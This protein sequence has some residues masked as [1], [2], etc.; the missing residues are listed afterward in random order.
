MGPQSLN[1]FELVQELR[2][3]PVCH[4]L[5]FVHSN[6]IVTDDHRRA[7]QLGADGFL[8]KPMSKGQ[9]LKLLLQTVHHREQLSRVSVVSPGGRQDSLSMTRPHPALT[10][11]P[12]VKIIAVID[13][14]K[15]FR[16]QWPPFLKGFKTQLYSCAEDFL[17][18]WEH[19]KEYLHAVITDKFLGS[20][21]DGITFGNILR[22]QSANIPIILS[23]NELGAHGE[24]EIFDLVVDKDAAIEAPKITQHILAKN[25]R[26]TARYS[27]T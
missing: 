19:L 25:S 12:A 27:M 14:E 2:K 24:G 16:D 11:S 15:L 10:L 5:I 9:L 26:S 22:A 3:N 8:P 1:G 7:G 13:D 6:R 18:D 23:T 20:G 4:A 21:M 17:K